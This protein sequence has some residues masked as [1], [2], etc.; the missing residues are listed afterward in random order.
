[1]WSPDVYE[2][3][4]MPVTA[5]FSIVPKIAIFA[6]FLRLFYSTFYDFVGFWQ[7][8]FLYCG[9][10]SMVV[11]S[12]GA[13]YQKKLKRLMAYSGIANVGYM[14]AGLGAA[15]PESAHGLIFYLFVYVITLIAF[16]SFMLGTFTNK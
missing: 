7:P 10:A 9:L 16:F 6:L 4:P 13:L 8:I 3:A 11:G 2:G 15:T 1:M 14:L 12:I 5:Y